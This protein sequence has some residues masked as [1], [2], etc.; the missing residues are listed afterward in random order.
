[1]L[2]KCVRYWV[3]VLCLLGVL[4]PVLPVFAAPGV[5]RMLNYQGR[6]LSSGGT[7]LGGTGT[8]YCFKFSFYDVPTVG[9]G[10][11][12]WPA[13]APSTMTAPVRNGVFTVGIGDTNIGGDVLDFNFQD[14]DAAYLNVEVATKV[15]ATCAPGDGAESFETFSP[16]QRILASGYAINASMVGGFSAAQY[17]SGNQIPVLASGNLILGGTNPFINATTT[18]ALTL[19]GGGQATGDIQFFS[20][21]N[22][23]T[24][25]GNLTL[26]GG[27][28]AAAATT[29]HAT[30]TTLFSTLGRFTN[31]IVNSLV[32]A[33][34]TITNLTATNIIGT[35]ATTTNATTTSLFASTLA[36]L[37]GLFGD[38]TATTSANLASTTAQGRFLTGNIIATSTATSSFAGPFRVG[39][40]TSSYQFSILGSTTAATSA[41]GT[42]VLAVSNSN[43]TLSSGTN[44]LRLNL[45]TAFGT[46]C[47]SGTTCPRF[48]E[49]FAGVPDN[50]DTGGRGV[51]SLRLSTAGTGITQTS[52]AADFAEYMVLNSSASV[53]DLVSLNSDGEYQRAVAGQSLIGVISDNPAFVANANLEGVPNAYVVGFAGVIE[54]TVS[55]ANGIIGAGDFIAA[56]T[57]AGV[58]VKLM[59]SGFTLGQALENW[60]GPGT[61]QIS[62]LV[63]PKYIDA[64]IVLEE[65][66]GSQGGISGYWDF[67]TSTGAIT[68]ASSSYALALTNKLTLENASATRISTS[69]ASSTQGFFGS[70]SIGNLTGILRAT[71]GAI[72]S[73][74]VN[75]GSDVT[76]I[77][78]ISNG[79]TGIST[80]PTYGQLLLGNAIGGYDLVATS[81]LGITGT[82]STTSASFFSSQ[83]LAFST[84]S[85]DY[86]KSVNNFFSTTST[87]YYISQANL[88]GFSTTS[89]DYW[90]TQRNFFS[91]SSASYFSSLGLA[92][93]T[94]SNDYWKSVNNFFST[95]SAAHFTSLGL[96][97]STTSSDYWKSVNNFF[98]TTSVDYWETQQTARTADDLT[99]NS[100]E[101]LNDVAAMTENY[102][103]LFAWN[104][105]TW[106]DFA[107]STLGIALADTAGT[108]AANRGGTG[109]SSISA[110]GILLGNYAGTG[111]QQL[112]TS[113]LGLLTTHVAEGANLY[114][115]DSR[116]QTFLNALDKG[117]FFSTTSAQH[118]VHSSSTIPKTYTANTF[119]AAQSF[120]GG[121]TSNALTLTGLNGPLDARNGVVS[122]TTSIGVLY[123]GTGLTAAPT[124]GQMLVGNASGGYTLTATSSLGLPTFAYLFPNNATTTGLGIYASSTIGSGTQAG[125]LTI[126]GGATTTGLLAVLGAGTSTFA[127]GLQASV[128]N[129]TS[130][131]AT[132]T[133]ANGINIGQGCVAVNGV[134]LGAGG[135]GGEGSG[136][137]VAIRTFT[138]PGVTTYTPSPGATIAHVVVTG[139]GG[140]GGGADAPAADVANETVGG[141][142]GAGASSIVVVDVVATTSV[143]ISVGSAGTAGSNTG[144]TGGTG[145][146]SRFSTFAIANGG[147][148][149]GGSAVNAACAAGS[150]GTAG[151]GGSASSGDL[152]VSGGDGHIG[153]CLAEVVFGGLGGSSYWGGGGRG[154]QDG[155]NVCTAGAT[156]GAYGAGGGGA[157]CEDVDTGA[158]GGAG[159]T[160]TVVVYEYGPFTGELGVTSGGTGTTTVPTY[161]QLLVGDGLGAYTLM[162]TSTL[163][164]QGIFSTTSALHFSSLGLAFSTTSNDFW[165]TQRNFFSTTSAN[166]F[167]SSSTTIPKTYTANTFTALQTFGNASSTLFSTTYASTTNLVVSGLQNGLL[168]VDGQGNVSLA[169]AGTD[170]ATFG[171]LFPGNATNT[172]LSFNGGLI[173]NASSSITA[174]SSTFSTSTNATSTNLFATNARFTSAT[175]SNLGITNLPSA[176]LATDAT[177]RVY[178]TTSLAASYLDV[179]GNWSGT[180]DGQEGSFYLANS[181]ST[182][183]ATNF[184]SLGLAFSTTSNDYWQTQRN[185]FSTT[186]A[187]F[188]VSSSTTI[189]KT[190][191]ANTFTALQ[192]FG[193]ASTTNISASY[194]SSTQGFFGSLSVGNLT[195]ILR[196]TAGAISATLVDLASDVNGILQ[197]ANGGTGWGNIQ[198]GTLLTGNG[199]GALATTTIGS[200]LQ[201]SG[202]TLALNTGNANTW[203]A[204]QNFALASSSALSAGRAYFGETATTTIDT[205]GN[206]VVA[207]ALNVTGNT[208][209]SAATTTNLLVT[210]SSTF[211]DFTS[212]NAT[213]S[214]LFTNA[215][216]GA[217]LLGC[218]TSGDKLLWNSLT[219]QFSCGVD[220]GASGSGISSL[221]A[222]GQPQTGATQTFASSSD[223]NIGITITSAGNAHTFAMNWLGMLGVS[224]GGTGWGNIQSGTLLTGNGT[225]ALATTTVGSSLQLA[226]ATLGLNLANANIWSGL[227]R[228]GGGAS[229]TALSANDFVAVG[230]TATTTIRGETNATSTFAGGIEGRA[231]NITTGTSTFAN[232]INITGGCFSVNGA[233]ITDTVVKL[234]AVNTFTT[235]QAYTKP[236]GMSYIVV[237][238]WGGGGGGGDG[239]GT[240]DGT[241]GGGSGGYAM[242]QFTVSELAGTTTPFIQIGAAGTVTASASGG[243]G[244]TSAFAGSA[245]ST[246]GGGGVRAN[247]A[248]GAG[249][250]G[251]IGSGGD[252]NMNGDSGGYGDTAIGIGGAGGDAPRGGVGGAGGVGAGAAGAAGACGGGGGGSNG[253]GTV[254]GVGCV[255]IYEYTTVTSGADLAENYPV[256][257]PSIGPGDIVAFD[258]SSPLVVTRALEEVKRP[259][260]GIVATAP[261]IVL[262]EKDQVGQRP[263]ALAGRIPTKVNL[264]GGVI[265]VGDRIALSSEAGV[266]RKA[267]VFDDTVGIALSAYDGTQEEA[268]VMLFVDLQRGIEI[269]ALGLALL[270][271]MEG[272]RV[273]ATSTEQFDFVDGV[274]HAISVR[275]Q[276]A[277]GIASTEFATSSAS[278]TDGVATSIA[279]STAST[280]PRTG[281]Q[282]FIASILTH[283]AEWFA[284]A[285]NGIGAIFVDTVKAKNEICIDDQCLTKEDV[286]SLLEITDVPEY[287]TL[288]EEDMTGPIEE[289]VPPPSAGENPPIGGEASSETPEAPSVSASPSADI[290]P[291]PE[292][293]VPEASPPTE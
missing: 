58:G 142:G 44:V 78:G 188:F 88:S 189:P 205:A 140:G 164:I 64:A 265:E 167:V 27:V 18:N 246:G 233:C 288:S 159:G 22:K 49:Y 181:F 182:T 6:L 118:F 107:T 224:R 65:Y 282:S 212:R 202:G 283:I 40:D 101:E 160:G 252:L 219:G 200:S 278:S 207:G 206:V 259:L 230:R 123:G 108:L 112:S 21:A 139:G 217:G 5:P 260:V 267:N 199:T 103:D 3:G 39:L 235:S 273:I 291:T 51:G 87:D 141:G 225:G 7:L 55:D 272:L 130:V 257:D 290:P 90:Q 166:F 25:Q 263:V 152:N 187:N 253:T 11:K 115:T 148:G 10:T 155:G 210:A 208:T 234:T 266:G 120:T 14:T 46:T 24:A 1:M 72:T 204:R 209:L 143:Q 96:T 30:S 279:T 172:L 121:L 119:T 180:F 97:F 250:A 242:E 144:G 138:T 289:I 19:Q 102:G 170:Y 255:V 163:G 243:A 67:S 50:A 45:R 92:F 68:L 95:T 81:S 53:G 9:S 122:A 150:W 151:T 129:V 269:D 128:L 43:P 171:Y 287:E 77:L 33:V 222:P 154:G 231:L 162:G 195:G 276:N 284:S 149:G 84:T 196:A 111:W 158:T 47:T 100:I 71:G 198:S 221:G 271:D 178:A 216:R 277:F 83:G 32:A 248:D 238:V 13:S 133:F 213:S 232:G 228:F 251:G 137:L 59:G 218:D 104:G 201:L 17:A 4:I 280:T 258:T 194:A 211:Q 75:L 168:R 76:G 256:T 93:S 191:T 56:S 177:G 192:T 281:E 286:R 285:T 31:I 249:G 8:E 62:V 132:S 36:S 73:T 184:A 20:A 110:A 34:A 173:A 98:S 63:F 174:L 82:F 54:T 270:G 26:A 35:N 113:T 153:D 23:I 245:T 179:T 127:G 229:T 268:T 134:C 244:G 124:F 52:G 12:L 226:S 247:G 70:L 197:V 37:S 42:A 293:E 28:T 190:Y 29:T 214:L 57:T 239:D 203:T 106:T 146:Q 169:V 131:S 135:G 237:E 2:N 156:A 105:S 275:L 176:L 38:I 91:T 126:S 15:G 264:E 80:A 262:G 215:F 147:V 157:S 114:Y 79:G 165:Q 161:G 116:V 261:G 60:N 220:A 274:M 74:L 136:V 117:Y 223:A 48:I 193:N 66:G 99:N 292:S 125:G 183:S 145:G 109:L 16:R 186:S 61:G 85:N 69:Y 227:Q 236:N 241:G 240:G 94:T 41:T 175:T 254:G 86:W 185:F 89:A